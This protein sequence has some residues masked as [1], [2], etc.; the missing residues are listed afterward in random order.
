MPPGQVAD[1]KAGADIHRFVGDI[2]AVHRY[3]ALVGRDQ[4]YNH[5]ETGCFASTVGAK[6]ANHLA[7]FNLDVYTTYNLFFT[8]GFVE[9]DCFEHGQVP[10]LSGI[11]ASAA[12]G[13]S[14]SLSFFSLLFSVSLSINSGSSRMW[15]LPL[16]LPSLLPWKC[17]M[18]R[19]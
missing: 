18:L 11:S 4:A 13:S 9:I 3:I 7:G 17:W 14:A 16:P 10:S 15:I 2:Y 19:S 12:L 6:Q 1:T 5:V 8:V